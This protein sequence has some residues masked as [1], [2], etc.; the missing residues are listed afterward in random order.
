MRRREFI[1]ALGGAAAW[2]VVARAQQNGDRVRRIGVLIPFG[3]TDAET[4]V[5]VAAFKQRF[6]ELGW[7]DGRNVR[8]DYRYTDGNPE[9]TR[10]A[11]AELVGLAPDA[12]LAHANPA[13]SSLM[14]VTRTIPIVFTQASDPVGSGFVSNLARPGGNVT[15][16]HSFEPAIGG[17]WLEIL[18]QVAPSV[19]RAAV[20]H[21]PSIA[22]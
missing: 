19:R 6:Q 14:Q 16:F 3:E 22:S 5:L 17:K 4:Q 9:R 15:G 1:A 20:I 8:F 18:K 7:T 13:V 11:G 21:H 10:S 12:I 2:P